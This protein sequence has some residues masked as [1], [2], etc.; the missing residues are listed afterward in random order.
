MDHFKFDE[1][2]VDTIILP[3]I[4][5]YILNPFAKLYRAEVSKISSALFR[6][7]TKFNR[8]NA[9]S[10]VFLQI[11]R[12]FESNVF[13]N[14]KA[15]SLYLAYQSKNF[16]E[17]GFLLDNFNIELISTRYNDHLDFC[18]FNFFRGL[19]ALLNRVRM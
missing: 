16:D 6:I 9:L 10:N 17:V 1:E 18:M 4:I 19:I 11:G 14:V 5:T 2:T 15:Y 8:L 12:S 3:I 7:Y 13:V